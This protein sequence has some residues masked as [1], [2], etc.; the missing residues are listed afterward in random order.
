VPYISDMSRR[1]WARTL[2]PLVGEIA[3]VDGFTTNPG[4]LNYIV[5][6]LVVAF[7]GD[8]PNY[9]RLNAAIGALEACKLELYRRA[10]APYEDK[11]IADNGDVYL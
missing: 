2:D 4:A 11:K 5:T 3:A 7:L 9:E 8:A 6:R 1:A 10:V